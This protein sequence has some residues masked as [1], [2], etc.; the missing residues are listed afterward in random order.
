MRITLALL[1]LTL[2][3]SGAG[4]VT[5]EDHFNNR[6]PGSETLLSPPPV[7]PVRYNTT[8]YDQTYGNRAVT[9]APDHFNQKNNEPYPVKSAYSSPYR[10]AAHREDCR[11]V[12]ES[13][14]DERN[15]IHR[16]CQDT[17]R[18]GPPPLVEGQV[19]SIPAGYGYRAGVPAPEMNQSRFSPIPDDSNRGSR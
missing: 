17:Q 9:T 3:V 19:S 13:H 2:A 18:L 8:L 7:G 14:F 5:A 11:L 12:T 6:S 16:V 1:V 15:N 4:S 10:Y